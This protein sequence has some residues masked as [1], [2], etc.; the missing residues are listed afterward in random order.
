MKKIFTLVLVLLAISTGLIGCSDKVK[1]EN[2]NYDYGSR[3]SNDPKVQGGKAYGS[4]NPSPDQHNNAFFEYSNEVSTKIS[5]MYGVGSAM[6][7]LTDKNAYVAILLD[8]SAVGTRS[9]KEKDKPVQDNASNYSGIYGLSNG[10]KPAKPRALAR[11]Y[12]SDFT[13]RD[14]KNISGE[15]K[16]TIALEVRR[17][18][19]TVQEVHIS[20]NMDFVNKFAQFARE[21]WGSRSLTP[22]LDDFNTTVQYHFA[23]GVKQPAPFQ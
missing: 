20:A 7:M 14:H 22:W 16:Q 15:L 13:V 12:N 23:D 19:P 6:V 11:Y 21:A 3:K 1:V 17:L 2:T 10:S 4:A 9:A 18:A 8:Q 5:T